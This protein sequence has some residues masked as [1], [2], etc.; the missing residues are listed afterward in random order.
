[1]KTLLVRNP[2]G[3]MLC[4]QLV[5]AFYHTF[6]TSTITLISFFKFENSITLQSFLLFVTDDIMWREEVR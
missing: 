4:S 3:L 5:G 6:S 2:I 1:M